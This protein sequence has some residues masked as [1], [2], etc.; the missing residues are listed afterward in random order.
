MK[1]NMRFTDTKLTVG[2]LPSGTTQSIAD[3]PG[4]LVGHATKIEDERV[5]TGVTIID[6]GLPNLFRNKVPAAFYAANGFGKVAGI[7]QVEELGL[8]DV[9]IALTNTTVVAPVAEAMVDIVAAQVPDLKPYEA[10]NAVVGECNAW[11][12]NDIRL[13]SIGKQE[14][15][16]AYKNRSAK[17]AV[18]NVGAGTG[19]RAFSWKGGIGSASRV[20][21]VQGAAYTIGILVQTNFGGSLTMLGVPI[22]KLLGKNA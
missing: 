7:T 15:E 8:L 6:P 22:G 12:V 16:E 14:V 3:V 19:T 9:P 18:G 11:I 17:V 10:V 21:A 13:K 5:R 1:Q 20:L 2:Y 4:V